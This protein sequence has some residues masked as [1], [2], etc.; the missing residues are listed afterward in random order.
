MKRFYLAT[1]IAIVVTTSIASHLYA[2]GVAGSTASGNVPARRSRTAELLSWLKHCFD[3][4]VAAAQARYERR[5]T[6]LAL[7]HVDDRL[8]KDIGVYRNGIGYDFR[9]LEWW[10]LGVREIRRSPPIHPM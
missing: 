3:R 7:R 9:R 6:M 8:L 1:M 4:S 2:V 10:Q 5:E